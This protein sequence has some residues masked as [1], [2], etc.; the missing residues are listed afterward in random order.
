MDSVF[1]QSVLAN[2]V[3]GGVYITY[4]LMQKC[5]SS[6][7]HYT[8]DGGLAFDLDGPTDDAPCPVEDMQKIAEM[9][10]A[11]SKLHAPRVNPV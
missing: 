6:R 5:L 7:C 8:R 2:V 4:K 9:I 1:T 10:Q 11:R 3:L